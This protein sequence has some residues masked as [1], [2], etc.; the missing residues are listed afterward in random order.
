[1][2]RTKTL[3]YKLSLIFIGG[4]S[5][6][7]LAGG[8]TTYVVQNRIIKNFTNSRLKSSVFEL[9]K[10]T[11]EDLIRVET[12][13]KSTSFIV[14][15]YFNETADLEKPT[16]VNS[17]LVEIQ[18][19]TGLHELPAKEYEDVCAHYVVLNPEYT[20]L[21]EDAP[22]GDGFFHVKNS[23][24][25]FEDHIVTNVLQYEETDMAHAGWWYQAKNAG[26]P[27][28][29]EPYHN[30]NINQNIFSYVVPFY[31]NEENKKLLGVIGLDID[32]KLVI[33]D[34]VN[35]GEYKDA[36][37]YLSTK[38]GNI[39]YHEDVETIKDGIYKVSDKTLKDL[40]GVEDFKQSQDGA[41]TYKYKNHNRTTMSTTLTNGL[42][43]G[44]SVR[45]GE[46]R[47]PIRLV[48]IIPSLVYFGIL[49]LMVFVF[50]L[51][52]KRYVK[53]LQDLH[54]AVDKV[55]KGDYK[56]EV[57]YDKDDEI[58]DLTNAFSVMVKAL[59]EKNKMITAMAF[60]DGL[61]GVKN[62]NAYRDIEKRLD[63]QIK[64]KTAKFA[65][66]ML[67]VD[68]LKMINDNLGHESGD[69]A[70]IGSCYSLCKGFSHSP[71][72]RVGGDEFVA[73]A[74]GDDYEKRYEIYE[75]LRNNLISVKN[76]KYEFSV[77]M[78]TYE[79]GVD[80]SFKDVFARADQEMY[81][82]KKAKR[83]YEQD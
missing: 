10:Q 44:V 42:T 8:V 3:S 20:G 60:T 2:K 48:I 82:N 73:I 51:L 39:V 35:T 29:L 24:G 7:M 5:F 34:I 50:Y 75:K 12:I 76:T 13:V 77:G 26:E 53:P 67:D 45:T 69:R 71:V 47:K 18:N 65:L 17:A 19:S 70:I 61:T 68:K 83:R 41:I 11:D 30:A 66:I 33:K 9:S 79:P 63:A 59:A 1:M 37:T 22:A 4:M 64:D 57:T 15:N 36:N 32:L 56:F 40:S 27:I 81:L 72:F 21:A 78:A 25:V 52:L 31:S 28:W 14:S 74:E 55:R 58:G 54:T 16:Y 38:E 49:V 62:S 43:Y 23:D 80:H 6:A 46:L